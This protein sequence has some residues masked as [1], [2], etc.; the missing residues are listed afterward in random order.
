M[1]FISLFFISWQT[2]EAR[3]SSFPKTP[4]ALGP[5]TKSAPLRLCGSQIK[6]L[7]F[8]TAVIESADSKTPRGPAQWWNM[9]H[10][11]A[12]S[13][14]DVGCGTLGVNGI[15]S[16]LAWSTYCKRTACPL[17]VHAPRQVRSTLGVEYVCCKRTPCPLVFHGV[18]SRPC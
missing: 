4:S 13:A 6:A 3:A 18:V 9:P 1:Q 16:Y 17:V 15:V 10:V 8:I 2:R 7:C 12:H 11:G 14:R 5:E